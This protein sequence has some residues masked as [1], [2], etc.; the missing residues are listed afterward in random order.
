MIVEFVLCLNPIEI[1]LNIIIYYF[2]SMLSQDS[3]G[4]KQEYMDGMTK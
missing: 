2:H 4:V 3:A 1:D